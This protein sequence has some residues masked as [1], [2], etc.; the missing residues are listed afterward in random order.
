MLGIKIQSSTVI[1]DSE[2]KLRLINGSENKKL[3]HHGM[4]GRLRVEC[5]REAHFVVIFITITQTRGAI[6]GRH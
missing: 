1:N 2:H 5:R 3:D 4:K 6:L